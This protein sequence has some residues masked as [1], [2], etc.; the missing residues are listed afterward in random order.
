MSKI[1]IKNFGPIKEGYQE[2]DGWL[3]IKKV[4]VFIGNQGSGKSTVAKVFSTLTWMEKALNRGDIDKGKLN[5]DMFYSFFKYQR[6]PNYFREDTVIE[7]EGDSAKIIYNKKSLSLPKDQ[8][9]NNNKF[10]V[11]KIMYV[12]AE[13]NFLSVIKN[14]YGL[15]NLP[16]TLYTFAEELRKGQ[17]ELNGRLLQLPISELKYK[18]NNDN[19][20]S[21][22]VGKNFELDLLESS[23]GFQSF[24][25]LY[26]VTKFLT[27]ELQKGENVLREQLNVE[28]SVRRNKEIAEVMFNT[29]LNES[30]KTR[31]VTEIDSKYLNTC[32]INIVEEPELNLFPTSQKQMLFSLLE[33]NNLSK[34]NKLV[35]T[36]H[37]PY[38]INYLT[39]AV[40]AN[41]L[42]GRVKA[43]ELKNKL[44]NIVPL[45][46]TVNPD[47]LAIYQLDENDGSIKLLDNYKGL[48]S[49]E[50]KLNDE[51]GEGNELFAR[52]LEI[53]QKL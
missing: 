27:D 25:P 52:L 20:T 32:F 13:R 50:N 22:I 3:D 46:S 26:L 34:E 2:N 43:D 39:L 23:S 11:P 30:E 19:E 40:E 14:A 29:G 42:K 48:P 36:T 6:I 10:N 47:E 51:L 16:D 9:V 35:M 5:L 17:L 37:S 21:Y 45:N 7:Y 44:R 28:Q 33:F 8:M 31:K 53:E 15:K 41:K 12:P 24:V 38:L 1:K 4:T 49:D 18:Y